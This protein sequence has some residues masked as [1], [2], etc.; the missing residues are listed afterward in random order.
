MRGFTPRIY[1]L[2][3]PVERPGGTKRI[4]AERVHG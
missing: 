1:R 3:R 4:P 2:R